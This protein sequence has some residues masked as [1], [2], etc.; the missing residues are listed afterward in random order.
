MASE[1]KSQI[2]VGFQVFTKDG[3]EEVGAVRDLCGHRPE[4]LVY[5]ENTGDVTLPVNAI[6]AVHYQKVMVDPTRLPADVQRAFRR[7]HDSEEF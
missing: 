2:R 1:L 7:A 5:V 6:T 3:G 4:I